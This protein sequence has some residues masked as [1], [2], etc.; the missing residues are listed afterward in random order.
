MGK[1]IK[2]GFSKVNITPDYPVPLAGDG[3]LRIHS[4]VLAECFVTSVVFCDAEENRAILVTLD[5][6]HT[7][8]DEPGFILTNMQRVPLSN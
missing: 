3:R 7:T 6:L 1:R 2:V 5:L 8:E 4:S